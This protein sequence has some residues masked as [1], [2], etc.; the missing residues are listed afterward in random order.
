MNIIHTLQLCPVRYNKHPPFLFDMDQMVSLSLMYRLGLV[1]YYQVLYI[2]DS[3]Y[4]RI[5]T[6]V[7]KS[8]FVI[9]KMDKSN[10]ILE[11][12]K[13]LHFVRLLFLFETKCIRLF[14]I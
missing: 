5:L 12:E 2:I 9:L 8:Y 13:L 3:L 14:H 7:L 4:S 1:S 6:D 11:S 10:G